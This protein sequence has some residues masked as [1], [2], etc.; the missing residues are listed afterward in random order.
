MKSA[1]NYIGLF[2]FIMLFSTGT[3]YYVYERENPYDPKSDKYLQ[4]HGIKTI[5]DSGGAGR[6]TDM[7]VDGERIY[8]VY[9]GATHGITLARSI[10]TGLS[11]EIIGI[12]SDC[13]EGVNS[14]AVNGK[15]VYVIFPGNHISMTITFNDINFAKS[16]DYGKSWPAEEDIKILTSTGRSTTPVP[17]S[18]MTVSGNTIYVSYSYEPDITDEIGIYLARSDDAGANWSTDV[19]DIY[20][21]TTVQFGGSA[22]A[23]GFRVSF[24]SITSNS[25][26][27]YVAYTDDVPDAG[28]NYM[29]FSRSPDGGDTWHKSS[30]DSDTDFRDSC[31]SITSNESYIFASYY[32]KTNGQLMFSRS[33]DNGLTWPSGSIIVIDTDGNVGEWNSIASN[34]A[35][36]YISYYDT[37][38]GNL[39]LA[40]SNDY[41]VTWTTAVVDNPAND[42]GKY[43][44]IAVSGNIVQISYYDDTADTLKFARSIDGGNTW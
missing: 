38:N 21:Q 22:P 30:I 23:G 24:S 35:M 6:Y 11:F 15:N 26:G 40:K 3:C 19:S 2:F 18:S 43:N 16:T 28:F 33:T 41:G 27:V 34:G 25:A 8:I 31:V 37:T 13:L 29:H 39:K 1:R 7:A 32:D 5:D 36:V 42:V 14:I 10:D 20:I 4:Y 44:S 17:K 12:S 9:Y